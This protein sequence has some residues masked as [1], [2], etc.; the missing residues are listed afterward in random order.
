MY[1]SAHA[2]PTAVPPEDRSLK[3]CWS[4]VLEGAVPLPDSLLEDVDNDEVNLGAINGLSPNAA[5]D[6]AETESVHQTGGA[7]QRLAG[8]TTAVARE[9]YAA[10]QGP[11]HRR[12]SRQIGGPDGDKEGGGGGGGS[13]FLSALVSLIEVVASPTSP[14]RSRDSAPVG[15]AGT[16]RVPQ[17]AYEHSPQSLAEQRAGNGRGGQG[18][19]GEG[20]EA[21]G[22]DWRAGWSAS[23]ATAKGLA[24]DVLP[25]AAGGQQGAESPLQLR[26][27]YGSGSE[28]RT[29]VSPLSLQKEIGLASLSTAGSLT[30]SGED[31]D[32]ALIRASGGG[33]GGGGDDGR[34]GMA[35]AAANRG[36][37]GV[38]VLFDEKPVEL[39]FPSERPWAHGFG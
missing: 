11:S 9:P 19:G 23:P 34:A 1:C 3:L 20:G 18:R 8:A 13:G 17:T 21:G 32:S 6:R 39:G 15:T 10:S 30:E 26:K 28:I 37:G 36:D 35:D 16:G 29:E 14:P 2:P 7:A 25:V 4:C 38:G 22:G 12:R 33:R 27:E 5:L 24:L 31:Y